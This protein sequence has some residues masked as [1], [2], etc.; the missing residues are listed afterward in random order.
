MDTD[1]LIAGQRRAILDG[2]ARAAGELARRAID[3]GLDLQACIDQGFAAGI[4]EAGRL[5]EDGDFFLPELMQSADAMKAAMDVVRPALLEQSGA[6]PSGPKV[7][8]G[9]VQG[10]IHDIG[11][12][13]VATM[14]AAGGFAVVDLGRDVPLAHFADAAEREEARIVALSALLTTT[15]PGHGKVIELLE[16]R[17]LRGGVSVLVGGAPVTQGFAREIGAD[18]F[19]PNAPEAVLEARRLAASGP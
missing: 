4:Q 16:Q 19:A 17:G 6:A 14:L 9:T 18:G 1:E 15:M 8:I 11:K 2:D 12:T 10:D 7:V 5:F 3:A 13:L